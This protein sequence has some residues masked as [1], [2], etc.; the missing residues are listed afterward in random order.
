MKV[1]N[2][3]KWLRGKIKA[4][5]TIL[6]LIL[7]LKTGIIIRI[8]R[9]IKNTIIINLKAILKIN[10]TFYINIYVLK[11]GNPVILNYY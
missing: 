7:I 1:R 2:F 8:I 5:I 9:K 6:A 10:I 4:K 11:I 3:G